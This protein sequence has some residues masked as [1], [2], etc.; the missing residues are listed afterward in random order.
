MIGI[1][2]STG[3]GPAFITNVE[4]IVDDVA[5]IL[6]PDSS[7]VFQSVVGSSG[8]TAIDV[9]GNDCRISQCWIVGDDAGVDCIA[10]DRVDVTISDCYILAL[11]GI[12]ASTVDRMRVVSNMIE[13]NGYAVE[14][15]SCD[16]AEIIGNNFNFPT[17]GVLLDTCNHAV[18]ALNNFA[19]AVNHGLTLDDSDDCDIIGNLFT[20]IGT[21]T[22]NTFDAIHLM[23]DSDRNWITGNKIVAQ[24][25]GNLARYGINVSAATCNDNIY[26][27]NW[28]GPTANFG[29]GPYNNAGTGTLNTWPAAGG[30]QGDNYT[31]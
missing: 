6:S 7:V 8:D 25:A 13:A 27:G 26:A 1:D 18:V 19:G 29:T 21:G 30:A 31:L 10:T 5:I 2:A 15:T 14:L 12:R 17:A 16:Q 9:E 28:A 22:T 4:V 11:D 24:A 23:T 20:S 3:T